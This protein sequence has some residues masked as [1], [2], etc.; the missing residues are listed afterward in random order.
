MHASVATRIDFLDED[1]RNAAI[2]LLKA[3]CSGHRQ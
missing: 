3:K 2:E 1:D